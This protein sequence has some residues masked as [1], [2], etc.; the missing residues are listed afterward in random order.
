MVEIIV[1]ENFEDDVSELFGDIKNGS[2]DS[3]EL[4]KLQM[5][6][7][8]I[9]SDSKIDRLI[10]YGEIKKNLAYDLPYQREVL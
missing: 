9:S 6:A 2:F 5:D 1:N 7:K 8:E 4:F 3:P 10:S